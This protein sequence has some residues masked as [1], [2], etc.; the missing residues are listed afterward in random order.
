MGLYLRFYFDA[1]LCVCVCFICAEFIQVKWEKVS[2]TILFYFCPRVL[3]M[4]VASLE[5]FFVLLQ[6]ITKKVWE[7]IFLSLFGCFVVFA[8]PHS[9]AFSIRDPALAGSDECDWTAA[10]L[11]MFVTEFVCGQVAASAVPSSIELN[12]ISMWVSVCVHSIDQLEKWCCVESL[13]FYRI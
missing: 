11:T 12:I 10:L 9:K 7:L 13:F 1:S 8:L 6:R 3:S 5:Y 2:L 4:N